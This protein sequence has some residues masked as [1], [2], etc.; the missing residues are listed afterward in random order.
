MRFALCLAVVLSG[1]QTS[2]QQTQPAQ[3]PTP[4]A[5][6]S[7]P[8]AVL[9]EYCVGCHNQRLNTGGVALDALDVT[10]AAAHADVWERVIK[11]LRAGTMPPAGMPRP[12]QATYHAVTRWLETEIDRPRSACAASS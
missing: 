8:R 4:P 2:A 5:A 12:D 10:Q 9:D 3:T 7:A 6:S 11:K 1:V